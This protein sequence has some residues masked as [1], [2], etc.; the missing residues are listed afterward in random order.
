MKDNQFLV[1]AIFMGCIMI[2]GFFVMI[3]R[4]AGFI[5]YT[6]YTIAV[7]GVVAFIFRYLTKH[8]KS[9]GLDEK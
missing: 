3:S 9:Q 6:I 7:G 8:D 4:G 5:P 2:A 1:V